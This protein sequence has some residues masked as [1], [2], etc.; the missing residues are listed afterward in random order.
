MT[1]REFI[2]ANHDRYIEDIRTLVN[3]RSV[4]S[5]PVPGAPYGEG[6]RRVQLAAMEMCREAG[7]EVV[8]C[9]GR[10]AYGQYGATRHRSRPR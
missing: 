9:D 3:I 1:Y 4:K 10:I 7:L 5:D 8:D 6:V 2:T